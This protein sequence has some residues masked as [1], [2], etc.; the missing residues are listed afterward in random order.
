MP[1]PDGDVGANPPGFDRG[2]FLKQL[3]EDVAAFFDK[4]FLRK[5]VATRLPHGGKR[6]AILFLQPGGAIDDPNDAWPDSP[7]RERMDRKRTLAPW[8]ALCL[9]ALAVCPASAQEAPQRKAGWWK[10][11]AHLPGGRVMSRNLCLDATS[12]ARHNIFKAQPGCTMTA[13]KVAGGYSY[14]RV[15]DGKTVTGTA[16]GDFNSAYKIE[17]SQGGMHITTDAQWMG[18]CPA[19]R[20]ADELW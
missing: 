19:G 13:S 10:M 15:C 4:A 11:D 2:A 6:L 8:I 9:A 18:A 16:I 3:G 20:S 17:E 7:R 1:S 14:K 12:D 5:T